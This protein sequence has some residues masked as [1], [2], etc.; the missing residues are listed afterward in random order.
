MLKPRLSS[1]QAVAMLLAALL[2]GCV[3]SLE[4]A[5]AS[6]LSAYETAT[7]AP[8]CKSLDTRHQIWGGIAAGAGVLG[9][10][11]GLPAIPVTD[12]G[13][14]DGL[15]ATSVSFASLSALASFES[16]LAATAWARQC[17]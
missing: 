10:G 14:K 13:W 15:V 9:A 2:P 6:R 4:S 3:G 5:R 7:P 12:T 1:V 17:P 8:I 16:N 11:S